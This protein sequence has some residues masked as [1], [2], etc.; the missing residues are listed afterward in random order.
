MKTFEQYIDEAYNFR[1][2][3]SQKKGFNQKIAFADLEKGDDLFYA[4]INNDG[5]VHA[6][7]KFTCYEMDYDVKRDEL[8]IWYFQDG[9]KSGTI[10]EVSKEDINSAIHI[11]KLGGYRSGMTTIFSTDADAM[12]EEVNS[13][14]K[15]NYTV[16]DFAIVK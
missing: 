10:L 15:K 2:G 6:M 12:L 14:T 4:Y 13:I 1:L 5:T 11:R 9:L 8:L 3:G 16:D 7:R